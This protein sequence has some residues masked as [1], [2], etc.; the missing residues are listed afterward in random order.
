M[1]KMPQWIKEIKTPKQTGGFRIPVYSP[2]IFGDEKKYVDEAIDSSWLSAKGKYVSLFEKSFNK[3]MGGGYTTAVSSGTSAL[4]L[5]LKMLNIKK[6]D[7][8]IVPDFTMISTAFAVSYIGAKP[9]FVDCEED[10]GNI[11][12]EKINEVLT[13]KTK[14]I[15]PVHI[16]GTPCRMDE[17]LKIARKYKLTVL[18]DTAEA[19]GALYKGRKAGTIGDI[20]AFSLYINKIITTGEGGLVY[21]RNK[22]YKT[23]LSTLNNYFFSKKRHFWHKKIGYNFRMS[24][25][26]AAFGYGQISHIE[27]VICKKKQIAFWYKEYLEKL[28]KYLIPLS[29]PKDTESIYWHIGYRMINSKYNKQKLREY[30]AKQRIETRA[31]FIPLHLQPVYRKKRE[32]RQFVNSENLSQSGILFPSSPQLKREQVAEICAHISKFFSK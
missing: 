18:E 27:E 14:A 32:T 28:S 1:Q 12:V 13:E 24:N 19:M 23:L 17:L 20:S 11:N 4:F 6:G 2:M 3:F 29:V 25:L 16:Y 31:F 8:V 21:S 15:I 26:Q 22:K 30:L 7:E 10:T 5:A 9:V